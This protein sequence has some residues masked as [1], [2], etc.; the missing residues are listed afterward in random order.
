MPRRVGIVQALRP[1]PERRSRNNAALSF[2]FVKGSPKIVWIGDSQDFRHVT[3]EHLRVLF[4]QAANPLFQFLASAADDELA[5]GASVLIAAV[6]TGT[7]VKR[8]AGLN[9]V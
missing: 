8:S 4:N 6:D 7:L 2:E 9:A 1:R 5:D 3:I